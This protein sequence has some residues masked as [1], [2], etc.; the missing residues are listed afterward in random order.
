[1]SRCTSNLAQLFDGWLAQ[2]PQFD[3]I[4]DGKNVV[5]FPAQQRQV[6]QPWDMAIPSRRAAEDLDVG[7]M[8]SA[9]S[10]QLCDQ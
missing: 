2:Q 10:V 9:V 5:S 4:V 7:D 8:L 6:E 1:M 3:A